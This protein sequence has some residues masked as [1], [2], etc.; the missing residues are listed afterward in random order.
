MY[1]N[2]FVFRKIKWQL[3]WPVKFR[4]NFCIIL[5]P[6]FLD[7]LFSSHHI[8]FCVN[9]II[10]LTILYRYRE[11]AH[12]YARIY[13]YSYKTAMLI[14]F[15]Y[16]T[17]NAKVTEHIVI[18]IPV[19]ACG[20]FD[21]TDIRASVNT[22]IIYRH[23]ICH[24]II[25]INFVTYSWYRGRF[26]MFAAG[27]CPALPWGRP[28]VTRRIAFWWS[29]YPDQKWPSHF[30]RSLYCL[31]FSPFTYFTTAPFTASTRCPPSRGARSS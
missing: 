23:Y 24:N 8:F 17:P 5:S 18:F 3:F 1:K 15:N 6:I 29:A 22:V 9:L 11:R 30:C 19:Y 12:W 2:T 4:L 10:L 20:F 16:Y 14:I 27:G 7:N 31:S 28:R 21:D 26:S 13:I 25:T